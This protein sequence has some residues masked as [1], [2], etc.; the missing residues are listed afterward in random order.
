MTGSSAQSFFQKK[1]INEKKQPCERTIR[2][3]IC[4][5]QILI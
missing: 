2:N 5:K 1:Q 3:K 4:E